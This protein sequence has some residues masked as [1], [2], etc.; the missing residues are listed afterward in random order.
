MSIVANFNVICPECGKEFDTSLNNTCPH[1]ISDRLES[2]KENKTNN[3]K[4]R[5]V[6]TSCHHEFNKEDIDECPCCG[7]PIIDESYIMEVVNSKSIPHECKEVNKEVEY[8][9]IVPITGYI[10]YRISAENADN[11]LTKYYDNDDNLVLHSAIH[12]EEYTEHLPMSITPVRLL[13]RNKI[14]EK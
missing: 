2:L 14:N 12:E 6:C 7:T 9:I 3:R 1:C 8:S 4:N 11:A 13:D 10:E 5:Y